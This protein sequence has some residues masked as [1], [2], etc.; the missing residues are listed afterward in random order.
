LALLPL[1]CSAL[2]LYRE[3]AGENRS[4]RDA[5]DL[6]WQRLALSLNPA[7]YARDR[8]MIDHQRATLNE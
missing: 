8:A 4:R 6:D 3:I 5:R 1:A 7:T 2:R